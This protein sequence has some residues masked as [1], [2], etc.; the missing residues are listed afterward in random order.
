M[1]GSSSG[2]PE[3]GMTTHRLEALSDGIFAIA[4]TL[5]VL[6]LALPEAGE[7]LAELQS[8]L[9]GQLDKFLSYA[10]SFILLAILWVM[11]HEQF[12]YI[13]R[14]DGRHLWINV[15][16]LMFV[17]LVPFS[18]SLVGDYSQE[19]VAEV[20]FGLNISMVAMLL[21]CSW[22]HATDHHRLVDPSLDPRR[23]ALLKRR[24]VFT[25]VV[26]VLAMALAFIN[27]DISAYIYLSI[28]VFLGV[29]EYR[30]RKATGGTV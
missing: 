14:T 6:N 12:H 3:H 29:S 30:H 22:L 27:P 26:P 21:L 5:L 2:A 11:H 19:A 20:F 16:F 24:G 25:S 17:A 10:V 15:F 9:L 23:V 13:K 18:T 28:P 1:A 7:G 8:L 4:M